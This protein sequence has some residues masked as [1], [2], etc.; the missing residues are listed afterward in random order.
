MNFLRY[1]S[2]LNDIRNVFFLNVKAF[3]MDINMTDKINHFVENTA[4]NFPA[5]EEHES[6]DQPK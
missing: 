5:V 6:Y 2:S 4:G 3:I 1:A